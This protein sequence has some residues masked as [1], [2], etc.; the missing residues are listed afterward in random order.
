MIHQYGSWTTALGYGIGSA[1]SKISKVE[2]LVYSILSLCVNESVRSI[3]T[4]W[5]HGLPGKW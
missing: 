2:F 5:P 4:S 3:Y 1:Y